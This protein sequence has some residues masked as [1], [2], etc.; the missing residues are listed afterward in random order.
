[1]SKNSMCILGNIEIIIGLLIICSISII[2]QVIPKLGFVAY[3]GAAAGSY[4]PANYN[5]SFGIAYSISIIFILFGV[6]QII[7]AI[8]KK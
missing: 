7:F 3:Q 8:R 2:K 6:L 1:M 5:M 4:N